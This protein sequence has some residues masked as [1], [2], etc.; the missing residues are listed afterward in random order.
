M[1]PIAYL[2][3]EQLSVIPRV[4]SEGKLVLI[5]CSN[6]KH[7]VLYEGSDL[8]EREQQQAA[9]MNGPRMINQLKIK[10]FCCKAKLNLV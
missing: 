6:Y 9:A 10:P 8:R 7:V 5:V 3:L 2:R 1:S 4:I